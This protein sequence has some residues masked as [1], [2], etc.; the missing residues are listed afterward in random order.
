MKKKSLH[1]L[2]IYAPK[3]YALGKSSP[4]ARNF[5]RSSGR[6]DPVRIGQSKGGRV[7]ERIKSRKMF[8]MQIYERER[9]YKSGY[10]NLERV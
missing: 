9:I 3:I 4:V 5:A 7:W 1:Q 2:L 6:T 10:D 8:L